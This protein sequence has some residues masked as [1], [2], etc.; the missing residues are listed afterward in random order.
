MVK[1]NTVIAKAASMQR[2]LLECHK[3]TLLM[4]SCIGVH[5]GCVIF[6]ESEHR[7]QDEALKSK[8]NPWH[9]HIAYKGEYCLF[10]KKV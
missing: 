6:M 9:M 10:Q 7:V 8:I 5:E 3:T 4:H 2:I 1:T